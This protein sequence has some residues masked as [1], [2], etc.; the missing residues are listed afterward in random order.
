MTFSPSQPLLLFG[1]GN[2]GRA[3]L[4]GWLASGI[5][6]DCFHVVD[7]MASNLPEGVRCFASIDEAKAPYRH[8]LLGIKPQMFAALSKNV[9]QAL[10]AD[11]ILLS[12]LA[13]TRADTLSGALP[14]RTIIR[15][16]PNLAA[17][18]GKA[19]IGIW[20][21]DR[22]HLST[23][24]NEM[25]SP[26]GQPIWIDQ[27]KQMDAVTALAGSGPAFVY[28]FIE[29]LSKAAVSL[30][31]NEAQASAMALSMVEGA[32]MLAAHSDDRP[33]ALASR[34]TS[35]GGTTA[36]GLAILDNNDALAKLIVNTL[37]A[38]RDRGIELSNPK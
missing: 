21:A 19:P 38:A 12:M 28:R 11:G 9:G 17:A 8:V 13:G 37:R 2:M 18:L 4:D 14:G 34:V 33:A 5:A 27:E 24:L 10:A 1:C 20:S 31:L 15:I 35:A 36:A 32:A 3:M 16:M 29:A 22:D 7:P 25:L 26:L 30:G 23:Q 6:A